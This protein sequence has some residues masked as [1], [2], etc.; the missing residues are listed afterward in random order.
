VPFDQAREG[1]L[2]LGLSG[3][4]F[5]F[6]G[7][8]T[9]VGVDFDH[10]I[11][12]DGVDGQVVTW[13]E[14]WLTSYV[15]VSP[16]GTGLHAIVKARLPH[17]VTA[18]K[19]P[20]S[21]T[22]ATVELYSSGRFFT[23]TEDSDRLNEMLGGPRL[24]IQDCQAGVNK[25][26]QT[27]GINSQSEDEWNT[28]RPLPRAT[29]RRIVRKWYK[30]LKDA[31]PGDRNN[32]LNRCAFVAARAF[33]AG[34]SDKSEAEIRRSVCK[35]AIDLGASGVD[36]T[37]DSGWRSGVARPFIEGVRDSVGGGRRCEASYATCSIEVA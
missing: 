29:I 4:G 21:E 14:K 5:V 11:E 1:V 22:D 28:D 17:N 20:G 36:G 10:S 37:F 2:K 31:A 30:A 26:L 19:L 8:D 7:G 16:S 6:R 23:V 12:G 3:L 35:V 25:L 33:A 27:L 18:T 15:E 32:S 34:V 9:Y 13:L 24:E